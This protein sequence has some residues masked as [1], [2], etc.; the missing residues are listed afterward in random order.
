MGSVAMGRNGAQ[1]MPE[2]PE[3]NDLS[4]EFMIVLLGQ[5]L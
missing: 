1:K 4:S 5:T 2:E 3:K